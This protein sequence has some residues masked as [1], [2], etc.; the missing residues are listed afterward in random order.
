MLKGSSVESIV[1]WSKRS[2]YSLLTHDSFIVKLIQARFS[3]DVM[4]KVWLTCTL[5]SAHSIILYR[6]N[7]SVPVSNMTCIV[8]TQIN[9][10]L[11]WVTHKVRLCNARRTLRIIA[12]TFIM[13]P[14]VNRR[15]LVWYQS[16]QLRYS[17]CYIHTIIWISTEHAQDYYSTQSAER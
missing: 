15:P 4:R 6:I 3:L 13:A 17:A 16:L 11:S 7:P 10:T 2:C 8:P 9:I 1:A 12:M 5:K 14:S